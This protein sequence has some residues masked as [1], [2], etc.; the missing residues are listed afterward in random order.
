MTVSAAS[1]VESA[2]EDRQ[3]AKQLLLL[4]REQV[5]GPGDGITHRPLPFGSVADPSGQYGQPMLQPGQECRRW[6]G[7][8]ARR[9]QL[10][11]E[12]KP[13]DAA[14]DGGNGL[15]VVDARG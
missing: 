5:I 3:A 1:R 6:Q 10:N 15:G 9:G 11:G 14:A 12:W 13:I 8:D 7:V 2:D 4:R